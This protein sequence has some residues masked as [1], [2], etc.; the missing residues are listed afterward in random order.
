MILPV[1]PHTYAIFA[2][3]MFLM[4]ITPGPAVLYS[5]RNGLTKR[6][7]AVLIGMAGLNFG[8]L[9]WFVAAALGLQVLVTT[10]PVVFQLVSVAGGVYLGWLAVKTFRGAL[11]IK[12]EDI[13]HALDA[14]TGP[15]KPLWQVF[16]DGFIVQILNPKAILFFS[17]VLPP[18]VDI[19]RPVPPQIA[20]FALTMFSFDAFSMTTYGLA[21]VSLSHVLSDPRNKQK[22]DFAVSA[23][24]FCI[25]A[26]IVYHA[27]SDLIMPH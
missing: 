1:D 2:V 13:G 7:A 24:L 22:F 18:F 11:N 3:T 5:I 23:I 17:A 19:H 10:F 25:A 4:A 12:N 9:I 20:V 21:A 27:S 26:V 15:V 8:N 16:K 6:P 14:D